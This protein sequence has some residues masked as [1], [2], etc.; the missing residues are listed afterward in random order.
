MGFS[1]DSKAR[2]EQLDV[3]WSR[4]SRA[5]AD[6]GRQMILGLAYLLC[7]LSVPL[8]RGRL[9]ALADLQLRRPWLAGAAIAIQIGI[10]SLFPGDLGPLGE[11]LHILSYL[12][13]GAFAWSNRRIAGL[14]IIALGGLLEL[15]LHHGQRRRHAG[16]PGR[17]GRDRPLADVGRVHQLDRARAPE[18]RASSATSSRRRPRW[19]VTTSTASATC[20]S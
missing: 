10:V 2:V 9:S 8:A 18:A 7:L 5:R 13:L 1:A 6:V 11:P 3:C 20:S 19:P 14:P 12:L 17:A 4:L 15:P 16:R